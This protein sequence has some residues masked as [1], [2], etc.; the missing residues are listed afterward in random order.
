MLPFLLLWLFFMFLNNE[1]MKSPA[2]ERI[3][4]KEKRSGILLRLTF[5]GA[6]IYSVFLPLKLE[7]T[8][9]WIG[10]FIYMIGIIF[11]TMAVLVFTATPKDRP[12]TKGIYR[13][14][15]NPMDLGGFMLFIGVGIACVSWVFL[16]FAV[17]LIILM[18][19]FVVYE[20]AIC[21][22]KYGDA[23]VEYRNHTPKWIGIPKS[24]KRD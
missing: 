3:D 11:F 2:W 10:L 1:K 5:F 8:L 22:G 19:K 12:V 23:Y 17:V 21:I 15:R 18:A 6:I 4:K 20:E 16:I 24:E 13:I 9:L 7:T 14:S